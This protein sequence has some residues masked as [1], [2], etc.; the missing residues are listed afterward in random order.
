MFEMSYCRTN[1]L[2]QEWFTFETAGTLIVGWEGGPTRQFDPSEMD[3]HKYPLKTEDDV[4]TQ[5]N[6]VRGSHIE[7][8]DL[9]NESDNRPRTTATGIE[10]AAA[11]ATGNAPPPL[12]FMPPEP[13]DTPR[14]Y[15]SDV[16]NIPPKPLKKP[17]EHILLTSR[18]TE[19][20]LSKTF[21]YFVRAIVSSFL[22]IF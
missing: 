11:M 13:E 17:V 10:I 9:A 2:D 1:F 19:E 21:S 12:F 16:S 6:S 14:T 8:L 22:H 4:L 20:A 7:A 18:D 5:L 15:R 3:G